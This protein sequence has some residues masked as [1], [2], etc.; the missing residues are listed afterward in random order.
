MSLYKKTAQ[1]IVLGGESVGLELLPNYLGDYF[2]VPST[3]LEFKKENTLEKVSHKRTNFFQ[4]NEAY[5]QNN[6]DHS[7]YYT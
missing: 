2:D 1:H 7:N 3:P 4:N 5:S 6:E